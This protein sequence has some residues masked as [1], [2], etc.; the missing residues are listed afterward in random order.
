MKKKTTKKLVITF[1]SIPVQHFVMLLDHFQ[2][3]HIAL[4]DP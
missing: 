3:Y 2:I 4:S 1:D